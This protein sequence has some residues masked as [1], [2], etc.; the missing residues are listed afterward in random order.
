MLPYIS[1]SNFF[2]EYLS[3]EPPNAWYASPHVIN[4]CQCRSFILWFSVSIHIVILSYF[5]FTLED[6]HQLTPPP[7]PPGLCARKG[8]VT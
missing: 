5:L 3:P 6:E 2:Y 4:R 1:I 8:T 7:P